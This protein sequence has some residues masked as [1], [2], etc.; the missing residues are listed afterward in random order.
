MQ[1]QDIRYDRGARQ[2][3]VYRSKQTEFGAIDVNYY[4]AEGRRARARAVR[5]MFGKIGRAV[6]RLFAA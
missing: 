6:G 1:Y 4:I 5:E 3:S 2:S